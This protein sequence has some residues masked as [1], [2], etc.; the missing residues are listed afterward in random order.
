MDPGHAGTVKTPK[1]EV[2]E[3]P[4]MGPGLVQGASEAKAG[5][6]ERS[7]LQARLGE[8]RTGT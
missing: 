6:Q 8:Q 7:S 3:V 5:Q 1:A 4:E 2:R